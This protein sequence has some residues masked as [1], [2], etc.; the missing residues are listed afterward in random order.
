ML[1]LPVPWIYMVANDEPDKGRDP[2]AVVVREVT[3]NVSLV[4]HPT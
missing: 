2:G 1:V 3:R 4:N